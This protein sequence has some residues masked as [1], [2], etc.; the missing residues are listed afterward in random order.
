M[1]V[2]QPELPS[3]A[4][5]DE[6]LVKRRSAGGARRAAGRGDRHADPGAVRALQALAQAREGRVHVAQHRVGAGRLADRAAERAEVAL[7]RGEVVAVVGVRDEDLRDL[8]E[9]REVAPDAVVGQHDEVGLE[10]GDPLDARLL[11]G[12]HV[13]DRARD[14]DRD[15]GAVVAEVGRADGRDAERD[16]VLDDVPVK[17]DDALGGRLRGRGRQRH[18]DRGGEQQEDRP[19][20][21]HRATVRLRLTI[22]PAAGSSVARAFSQVLRARR[23]VRAPE[24]ILT[25]SVR[26]WPGG[27]L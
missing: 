13:G 26:R 1:G 12:A 25:F 16:E 22:R 4:D 14:P 24:L 8:R 2:A 7:H 19:A 6:L 18:G 20:R 21:A 27:T 15:V 9:H 17:R 10:L 5:A 3:T 23:S 11:A